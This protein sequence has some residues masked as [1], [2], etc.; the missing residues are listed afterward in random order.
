MSSKF[1]RFV[2]RP[3]C[4]GAMIG[5][6][7]GLLKP[8]VVYEIREILGDLVIVEVGPSPLGVKDYRAARE[9]FGF[10]NVA[11]TEAIMGDSGGRFVLTIDEANRDRRPTD[12]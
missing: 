4:K 11:T 5:I 8:G 6:D 7:T 2:V 10:S 3:D 9:H 1:A 12:G